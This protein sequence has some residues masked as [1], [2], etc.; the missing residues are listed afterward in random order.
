M[1][2]ARD[3]EICQQ[4][5]DFAGDETI[6][7]LVGAFDL[8]PVEEMDEESCHRAPFGVDRAISMN[9]VLFHLNDF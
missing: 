4:C 5:G 9:M 2:A 8:K 6:D 7:G 1:G 3:G